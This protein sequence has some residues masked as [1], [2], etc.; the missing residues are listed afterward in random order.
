MQQGVA[1]EN[2]LMNHV[3]ELQRWTGFS[4]VYQVST[5]KLSPDIDFLRIPTIAYVT[6]RTTKPATI[7]S[8]IGY[9]F[10]LIKYRKNWKK[11]N[12]IPMYT[13][14]SQALHYFKFGVDQSHLILG[15]SNNIPS[16][17][18]E[19]PLN[20]V[21]DLVQIF[22][23]LGVHCF[24]VHVW[25]ERTN[26]FKE[27]LHATKIFPMTEENRHLKQCLLRNEFKYDT[28]FHFGASSKN[29]HNRKKIDSNT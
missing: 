16:D 9:E 21:N 23:S 29:T 17:A 12:L 22:T 10:K 5:I 26:V 3:I 19:M 13:G 18:L 20:K 27:L 14:L 28:E 8:T 11:P 25:N 24:G 1:N 2:E 4:K 6:G 7:K 15:L